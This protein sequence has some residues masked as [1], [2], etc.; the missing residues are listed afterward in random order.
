MTDYLGQPYMGF[1]VYRYPLDRDIGE[2]YDDRYW[3]AGMKPA[4]CEEEW[5]V[6]DEV[7][8][9][10]VYDYEWMPMKVYQVDNDGV[11]WAENDTGCFTTLRRN[12]DDRPYWISSGL[13][14]TPYQPILTV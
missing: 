10:S 13:M 14:F 4:G 12:Q 5:K 11:V 9:K 1:E 2:L 8:V 6:G 7:L 3:P